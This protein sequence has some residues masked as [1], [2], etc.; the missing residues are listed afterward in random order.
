MIT[1]D[2]TATFERQSR[3]DRICNL[4]KW[5][6]DTRHIGR[7]LVIERPG[8]TVA[9]IM[10]QSGLRR[11][12]V[13]RRVDMLIRVGLAQRVDGMI[14]HTKIGRQFHIMTHR[15]VCLIIAGAQRGFSPRLRAALA[16]RPGITA[17]MLDHVAAIS[18]IHMSVRGK[19]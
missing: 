1:D 12:T 9:A 11:M 19:S 2:E 13:T 7:I 8:L 14:T 17:E 15:E 18:Y 10:A 4:L 6:Y 5:D 3:Y 16:Q